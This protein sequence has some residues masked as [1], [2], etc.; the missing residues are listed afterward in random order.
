MPSFKLFDLTSSYLLLISTFILI[1]V[2]INP[3]PNWLMK[4]KWC[5]YRNNVDSFSYKY[6][7]YFAL[8]IFNCFKKL[9]FLIF[10]NLLTEVWTYHKISSVLLL[11]SNSSQVHFWL[12][13]TNLPSRWSC[14][15]LPAVVFSTAITKTLILPKITTAWSY[16]CYLFLHTLFMV[17]FWYF[18]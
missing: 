15:N 12:N 18:Y 10:I 11:H 13:P 9:L 17:T 6:N 14:C 4:E 5:L 8:F 2:E 1:K 16:N 3:L 7:F